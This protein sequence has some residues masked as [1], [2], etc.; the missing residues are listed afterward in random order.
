MVATSDRCVS[1]RRN[2]TV[3][4]HTNNPSGETI[5]MTA[6][7]RDQLRKR[8]E[9]AEL[10]ANDLRLELEAERAK[11]TDAKLSEASALIEAL[12]VIV[13]H[14]C[15]NLS[16]EFI[17]DLPAEAF[18]DAAGYVAHVVG[19]TQRDAERASVWA[20]RAKHVFEWRDKRKA[21]GW[22]EDTP[23]APVVRAAEV[24]DKALDKIKAI[25]TMSVREL[26][27][28]AKRLGY[29]LVKLVMPATRASKKHTRKPPRRKGRR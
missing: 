8:A 4:G 26:N 15:A 16:P 12:K 9:D 23:P 24:V 28:A 3:E 7:L 11:T 20:E 22:G 1:V 25:E 2:M 6:E 10:R 14:A 5:T 18:A 21:R 27:K 19:A 17:R 29:G 13:D